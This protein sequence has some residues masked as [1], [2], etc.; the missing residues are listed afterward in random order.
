MLRVLSS[1]VA[2]MAMSLTGAAF[3][4]PREITVSTPAY[5]NTGGLNVIAPAFTAETGIKVTIQ[6]VGMEDVVERAIK[7]APVD[8]V[9]MPPDLMDEVAKAGAI[10]TETRK[11]VGR[12]YQG[13]AVR[14]GDRVPD[15]S[16]GPKF[17]AALEGANLVT[18]SGGSGSRTAVMFDEL[19]K[20]PEFAKVNKRPSPYSSGAAALARNESDMA[21]Q[22]ISQIIIWDNLAVAGR[23]PAEY[24]MHIDAVAAVSAKSANPA[25]A[26]QFLDYATQPGMFTL[27]HS[28]GVDPREGLQ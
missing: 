19:L 24:N 13:L 4:Q 22:N 27:W 6:G 7:G 1:L 12:S 17:V 3:A 5:M 20:R 10:R 23:I 28:R 15:I 18:Y 16:S 2:V 26:R 14:K 9:F 25:L 21:L 11:R 8:V